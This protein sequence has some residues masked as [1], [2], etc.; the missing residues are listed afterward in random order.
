[1]KNNRIAEKKSRIQL[2]VDKKGEE[3]IKDFLNNN[4]IL[5]CK[6]NFHS[7]IYSSK[8][9]SL[10]PKEETLRAIREILPIILEPCNYHL[11]IF[12]HKDLLALRYENLSVRKIGEIINSEGSTE[13]TPKHK[14]STNLGRLYIPERSSAINGNKKDYSHNLHITFAEDFNRNGLEKLT[15]FHHP[16]TFDHFLWI[17]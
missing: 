2:I 15:K 12:G 7:T 14:E 9:F 13:V 5:H 17:A 11:R 16:I 6:K 4:R 10:F 1:M 3:E 8:I